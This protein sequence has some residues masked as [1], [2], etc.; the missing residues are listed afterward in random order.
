MKALAIGA[1]VLILAACGGSGPQGDASSSNLATAGPPPQ[2]A[3][4]RESQDSAPPLRLEPLGL[5][6]VEQARLRGAGCDF[7]VGEQLLLVAAEGE[8]IAKVNGRVVR[9]YHNAALGPTGGF[10]ASPEARISV[11]RI[12]GAEQQRDEGMS[13][14]ARIA[15]TSPANGAPSRIEGRW[16]CGS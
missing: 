6:E 14:P 16:S 3:T 5:D 11:G 4:G 12:E 7:T 10:F 13:W 8:A 15:A 9:L 2:P 1:T